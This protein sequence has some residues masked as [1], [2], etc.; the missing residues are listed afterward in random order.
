[1]YP[2][3]HASAGSRGTT[4]PSHLVFSYTVVYL[5]MC[6]LDSINFRHC[7]QRLRPRTVCQCE[8]ENHQ[9]NVDA[10]YSDFV[11]CEK[12]VECTERTEWA[13]G[14]NLEALQTEGLQGQTECCLLI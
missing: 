6:A 1:M 3:Y 12:M 4:A 8:V 13:Q 2:L 5:H 11:I 7:N 9:Q 14:L 10:P